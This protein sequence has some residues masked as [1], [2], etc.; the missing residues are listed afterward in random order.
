M[1]ASCAKLSDPSIHM[2]KRLVATPSCLTQ[3][4]DLSR[5]ISNQR[6]NPV[7]YVRWADAPERLVIDLNRRIDPD[8][9]SVAA[10][11]RRA[12]AAS[13]IEF[14][15]PSRPSQHIVTMSLSYDEVRARQLL[16]AKEVSGFIDR[17]DNNLQA[18]TA[19]CLALM[20]A[21]D[22]RGANA[23]TRERLS[24]SFPAMITI[25]S[26]TPDLEAD[27]AGEMIN[28]IVENINNIRSKDEEDRRSRRYDDLALAWETVITFHAE[29]TRLHVAINKLDNNLYNNL[30]GHFVTLMKSA[31]SIKEL[32]REVRLA[33]NLT[34][35]VETF[36]SF[37][38][39]DDATDTS[40]DD[41]D[42]DGDDDDGE[43][44]EDSG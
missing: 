20:F 43:E 30:S 33:E 2:V 1:R 10:S 15:R 6:I 7:S 37:I 35:Q 25:F 9:R 40:T 17:Y 41:D 26:A 13:S 11:I 44:G 38:E 36:S 19:A 29:L 18:R 22:E 23:A 27:V 12:V 14:L 24:R 31:G 16:R 3:A 42:D 39:A 8:H 34:S 32:Q 4:P 28:Q 21:T 5:L